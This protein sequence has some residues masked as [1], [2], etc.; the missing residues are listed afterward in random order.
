MHAINIDHMIDNN[1]FYCNTICTQFHTIYVAK[2]TGTMYPDP[3][4]HECP[5]QQHVKTEIT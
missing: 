5:N 3:R 4:I 1:C 2:V